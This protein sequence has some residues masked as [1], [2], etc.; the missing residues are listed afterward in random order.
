MSAT[1]LVVRGQRTGNRVD[2][3]INSQESFGTVS[4]LFGNASA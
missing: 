3:N 4:A 2:V 1:A